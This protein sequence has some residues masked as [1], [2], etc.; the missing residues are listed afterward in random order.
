MR[1]FGWYFA[2]SVLF[3]LSNSMIASGIGAAFDDKFGYG[4]VRAYAWP[5]YSAGLMAIPAAVWVVMAER[6]KL[7]KILYHISA[8]A[9]ASVL[10]IWI[11]ALRERITLAGEFVDYPQFFWPYIRA[12]ALPS[13]IFGALAGAFGWLCGGNAA[14]KWQE[15]HHQD[16]LKLMELGLSLLIGAVL[17]I[18]LTAA[19]VG[20]QIQVLKNSGFLN[21]LLA[22]TQFSYYDV[23]SSN[24]VNWIFGLIGFATGAAVIMGI[25][26]SGIWRWTNDNASSLQ[27]SCGAAVMA[28]IFCYLTCTERSGLDRFIPFE[29]WDA[30][31]FAMAFAGV[32]AFVAVAFSR[33]V[34]RLAK[35]TAFKERMRKSREVSRAP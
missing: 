14:G 35:L 7:Q 5:I 4:L 21:W 3:G 24:D 34:F 22:P 11:F 9:I 26:I 17:T 2:L 25:S 12:V 15:D 19:L 16:D 6:F 13:L 28:V 27:Q 8:G 18:G 32:S 23:T 20:P 29:Q 30:T 1:I 31:K 10:A 33:Y